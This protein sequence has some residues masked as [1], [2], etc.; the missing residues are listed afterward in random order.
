MT[1]KLISGTYSAGYA[2]A[3]SYS[4]V[5][6]APT[7]EIGGTG[8]SASVA[9]KAFNQGTVVATGYGANGVSLQAGGELFNASNALV[10]G[11]AGM[12]GAN[13]TGLGKGGAGGG[14]A[15]LSTRGQVINNGTVVGGAGG[16]GATYEEGILYGFGG[17]G[18][19]ALT[20]AADAATM[21]NSGDIIGGVGGIGGLGGVGGAGIWVSGANTHLYNSGLLEG[22]AGGASDDLVYDGGSGGD[23]LVE[24]STNTNLTNKGAIV[25]GV[26]GAGTDWYYNTDGGLAYGGAGGAGLLSLQNNAT[27][28]NSGALLG[29]AG[30]YGY[31]GGAGGNGA[32]FMAH[33]AMVVNSGY[34]RGGDAGRSAYMTYNHN[35]GA[36]GGGGGVGILMSAGGNLRNSGTITGGNGGNATGGRYSAG[37]GGAGVEQSG[38]TILNSGVI[39]GGSGGEGQSLRQNSGGGGDGIALSGAVSLTNGGSIIGGDA[40]NYAGGRGGAGIGLQSGANGLDRS[41]LINTGLIVGGVGG[42]SAG[43]D[44]AGGFGGDGILLSGPLSLTNTGEISGGQGGQGGYTWWQAGGSGGGGGA[45]IYLSGGNILNT[46]EVLGGQ[47]GA[48]GKGKSTGATGASGVGVVARNAKVL[49]GSVGVSDALI[50]GSLG[51]YANGSATITN[52]GTIDGSGGVAIQFVSASGR[53]V[54]EAGSAFIGMVDAR[55]GALELTSGT[56]TLT[57]L[58]ATGTISGALAMTFTGFGS[59]TIDPGSI[60]ALTGTNL[61][62]PAQSLTLASG[63]R[64]AVDG[65]ATLK[66]EGAFSQGGDVTVGDAT[67][68]TASVTILQSGAWEV[69]ANIARGAAAGN[70]IIDDGLLIKDGGA[71]TS[72]VYVTTVDNGIV[73]AAA[74]VLDFT[75]GLSGAGA[76]KIDPGATLEADGGAV[77]GLSVTFNG[78]GA[79][80]ALKQASA[81][82]ATISGL[83]SGDTIDLLGT[84]AT[85]ASVNGADQLVV[86]NGTT[87]VAT[88]QLSGSY[89]GA[90]FGVGSDGKGGTDI[91][92]STAPSPHLLT[93]AMAAM[94]PS[95]GVSTGGHIPVAQNA[96]LLATP[97]ATSS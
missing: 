77:S 33:G 17:N 28:K 52:F 8:L 88:L 44:Y 64:L 47:G 80:L 75:R 61:V 96:P 60:W 94:V 53:L 87:T 89:A 2:L 37:V 21:R 84:T 97:G 39:F 51:I 73:E 30:G 49:N 69:G 59:Y 68:N 31:E 22:A 32:I 56:G 67:S 9:A 5:R 78:A 23:G 7:G 93:A 74:G 71:G 12:A 90:T 36:P 63:A 62:R 46:G 35:Q 29:G 70:Q 72:T 66:V 79:T 83:V 34:V 11:G 25:G 76:I 50:A 41:S 6:I 48:G 54:A 24:V 10:E 91:T 1:N 45:G 85:G 92:L 38:G 19:A 40:G 55:G 26:G 86:V 3:S 43:P 18:G 57:G 65:G 82:A 42:G 14:G 81:F 13:V 20:V 16:R 95:A 27:L 58:G 15:V 4:Q